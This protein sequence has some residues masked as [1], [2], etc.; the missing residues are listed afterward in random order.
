[1]KE[2]RALKKRKQMDKKKHL[3]KLKRYERD[4]KK[5]YKAVFG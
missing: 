2:I 3:P 1:L 5:M 4:N